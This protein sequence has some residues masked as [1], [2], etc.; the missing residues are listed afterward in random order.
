MDRLACSCNPIRYT[1]GNLPTPFQLNPREKV[2]DRVCREKRILQHKALVLILKIEGSSALI[3]ASIAFSGSTG[4]EGGGFWPVSRILGAETVGDSIRGSFLGGALASGS[5]WAVFSFDSAAFGVA[6]AGLGLRFA[7]LGTTASRQTQSCKS[8]QSLCS[9]LKMLRMGMAQYEV[10]HIPRQRRSWWEIQLG[11]L[12]SWIHIRVWCT[13][14]CGVL[15]TGGKRWGK[16]R[17]WK[18]HWEQAEENE[19]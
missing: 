14:V 11:Q 9:Y 3:H 13:G 15:S 10:V 16:K 2:I 19:E 6:S 4:G 1:I 18:R 17:M 7:R 12:M 8:S 5:E